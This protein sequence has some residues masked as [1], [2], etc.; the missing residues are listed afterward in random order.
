MAEDENKA[1]DPSR[2][3]RQKTKGRKRSR[4]EN[5]LG[6][7]GRGRYEKATAKGKGTPSHN[8][9]KKGHLLQ[10]RGIMSAFVWGGSAQVTRKG[11]Q[12]EK[13]KKKKDSIL[14]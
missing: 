8:K 12:G 2:G 5:G 3:P 10:K 1:M 7:G 13:K 14:R 6:V 9:G 4:N 11:I